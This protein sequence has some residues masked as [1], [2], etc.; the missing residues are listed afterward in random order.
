MP[1]A[2]CDRPGKGATRPGYPQAATRHPCAHPPG[3][4]YDIS[5]YVLDLET[6]QLLS[7]EVVL[8]RSA[9]SLFRAKMVLYSAVVPL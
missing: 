5:K 4:Q 8:V 9:L 2:G 7:A 6:D 1:V 3:S